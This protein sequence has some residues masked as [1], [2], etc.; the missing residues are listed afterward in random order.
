MAE[1]YRD[2]VCGIEITSANVGATLDYNGQT[3][4]FCSLDCKETFIAH[5]E[6]F[7]EK[8]E[9]EEENPH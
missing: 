2:P 1:T 5:P 8:I 4:Y 6:E 3:Y 7:V 9:K